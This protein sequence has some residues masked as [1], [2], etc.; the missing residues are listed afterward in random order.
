MPRYNPYTKQ[1]ELVGPDSQP[2]QRYIS[3]SPSGPARQAGRRMAFN[4]ELCRQTIKTP[5][6]PGEGATGLRSWLG[7]LA[8]P[9]PQH[10]RHSRGG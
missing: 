5:P 9:N 3:P 7:G 6:R 4:L 10:I 8:N 2:K 1:R